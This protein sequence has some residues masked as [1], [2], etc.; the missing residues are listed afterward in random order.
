V[1]AD[2]LRRLLQTAGVPRALD[3][4]VARKAAKFAALLDEIEQRPRD[5]ALSVGLG[6]L[7]VANVAYQ[8]GAD[9]K[10]AQQLAHAWGNAVTETMFSEF[11]AAF[12]AMM[13]KLD[14]DVS[15]VQ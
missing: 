14:G 5:W 4:D 11:S 15:G 12:V 8:D 10:R 9:D 7:I 2:D 1:T 3:D 13:A 6:A